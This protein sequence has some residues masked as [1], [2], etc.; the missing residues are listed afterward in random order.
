MTR[1]C[2][3][4]KL[5]PCPALALQSQ[6]HAE[7]SKCTLKIHDEDTGDPGDQ[8]FRPAP[9]HIYVYMYTFLVCAS[10]CV[11]VRQHSK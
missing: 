4:P 11:H 7:T 1:L 3:A 5:W 10:C 6:K 2:E 9:I 8:I